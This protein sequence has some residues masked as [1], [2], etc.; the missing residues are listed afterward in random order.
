MARDVQNG[1]ERGFQRDGEAVGQVAHA[2]RR[3]GD[4][5]G[6][7]QR[8]D[9]GFERP[10]HQPGRDGLVGA[11]IELEPEIVLGDAGDGL[12]RGRGGG[13][14]SIGDVLRFGCGGQRAV[15]AGADEIGEAH[16][17]DAEGRAITAAEEGDLGM[18]GSAVTQGLRH[19]RDLAEARPVACHRLFGAGAAFDE[20]IDRAGQALAGARRHLGCAEDAGCRH[21]ALLPE[22]CLAGGSAATSRIL[23]TGS[24]GLAEASRPRGA[25]SGKAGRRQPGLRSTKTQPSKLKTSSPFWF[26]PVLRWKNRP[27]CGREELARLSVTS[28]W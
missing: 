23:P 21:D 28:E 22:M 1:G 27:H 20:V 24:A 2:P 5:D 14:E 19:Q 3:Y 10:L 8:G 17:G 13:G 12:D 16:G 26:T 9:A 6:D 18:G 4:V 25:S 15:G 7:D 11:R